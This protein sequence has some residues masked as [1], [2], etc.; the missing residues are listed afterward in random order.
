MNFASKPLQN[1]AFQNFCG[2]VKPSNLR[3]SPG[4]ANFTMI[5]EHFQ[6]F[7]SEITRF[8]ADAPLDL[9]RFCKLTARSVREEI[10]PSL[11]CDMYKRKWPAFYACMHYQGEQDWCDLYQK[12]YC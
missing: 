12:T 3:A 10:T 7:L 2:A 9:V 5:V 1:P 11:W 6:P 4:D 8:L